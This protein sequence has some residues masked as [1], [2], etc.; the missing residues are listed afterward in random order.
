M[1][2]YLK[3][4]LSSSMEVFVKGAPEALIDICDRATLPQDFDDLLAYYTH[5]GFRVIA[6]AGKSLPGLS[7]VEAQRLPREKAESGLSFLGLIVFENKLKPGSLPAIATLRNANIGCKMV[8][9]DN[10]RTAVSVAREC[11]IL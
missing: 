9:G 1:R 11:G 4:L 8:T 5:H 6:C 7:W 3:Q 10:P 2:G